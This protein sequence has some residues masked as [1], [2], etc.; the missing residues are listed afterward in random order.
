MTMQNRLAILRESER[1]N[2]E[3]IKNGFLKYQKI[4]EDTRVVIEAGWR[5]GEFQ[6][7]AQQYRPDCPRY[8]EV[9]PDGWRQT[10]AEVAYG[11]ESASRV[12]DRMVAN[13]RR[14]AEM[15]R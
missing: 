6:I 1:K 12:F 5:N 9:R 14:Y 10:I 7:S 2:K 8:W 13:E 3:A 15:R 4:T 11:F